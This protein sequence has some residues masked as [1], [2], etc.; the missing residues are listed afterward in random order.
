[1][2]DLNKAVVGMSVRLLERAFVFTA[3]VLGRLASSDLVAGR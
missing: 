3:A 1:M 2:P